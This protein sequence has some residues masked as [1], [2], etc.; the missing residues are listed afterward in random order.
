M[1]VTFFGVRGSCPVSGPAF[2]RYG[3]NTSCVLVEPRD[4]ESKIILDLGTGLHPLGDH[5]DGLD[6]ELKG[7]RSNKPLNAKIFVTHLHWDHIQ[8]LPFFPQ[9]N[10]E[11]SRLEIFGPIQQDNSLIDIYHR[12]MSPP[13]FPVGVWDLKASISLH[14]LEGNETIID[15]NV[16]VK[17]GTI[18][19]QGGLTLGYRIESDYSSVVYISDHQGPLNWE[20][21][22]VDQTVVDL[23]DNCDLL[24]H[25]GQYNKQEF[26]EKIDW[27]HCTYDYA[28]TVAK[29]GKAKSLALF[30][31]DPYHSDDTID[32]ILNSVKE[33]NN[34][35]VKSIY[36][37][38]EG[39]T[40]DL[41]D[42]AAVLSS[43]L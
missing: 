6:A 10:R 30:H 21:G 24:I 22:Y 31:H 20:S 38:S 18:P 25:D 14:G 40:I 42:H 32:Q 7:E 36:A 28:L 8:G 9:A 27:G 43:V 15:S 17:V 3:G 11:K 37:A 41:H 35:E 39:M 29:A 2:S 19:H 23:V 4:F 5:L 1:K 34:G 16:T 12:F 26:E 33:K 13:F